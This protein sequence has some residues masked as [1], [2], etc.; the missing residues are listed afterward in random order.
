[1]APDALAEVLGR[2][3]NAGTK[4]LPIGTVQPGGGGVVYDLD[5]AGGL[6]G[7]GARG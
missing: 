1:V 2:L 6:E 7:A 5:L 4:G 3:R